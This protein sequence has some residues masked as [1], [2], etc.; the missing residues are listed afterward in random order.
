MVLGM[1]IAVAGDMRGLILAI[2]LSLTGST[3]LAD[4]ADRPSLIESCPAY[5]AHL[6]EAREL[7]ERGD[8]PGA[9]GALEEAQAALRACAGEEGEAKLAFLLRR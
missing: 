7:L 6:V 9:I 8:R 5:R 3:A 1:V 2:S 4:A